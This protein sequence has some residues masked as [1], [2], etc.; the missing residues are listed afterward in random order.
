M[1]RAQVLILLLFLL[2]LHI[3]DWRLEKDNS[4]SRVWASENV[5]FSVWMVIFVSLFKMLVATKKKEKDRENRSDAVVIH[6][7]TEISSHKYKLYTNIL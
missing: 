5:G 2:L 4:S 7:L 6:H 1:Q 3:F